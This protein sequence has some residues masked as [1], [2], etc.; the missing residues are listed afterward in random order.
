MKRKLTLGVLGALVIGGCGAAANHTTAGA[1][2]ASGTL[3]EW[4]AAVTCARA[5][6][7]PSLPDPV[8]GLDGRVTL[9]GLV[10]VPTPTPSVQSACAAQIRAIPTVGT[11][12]P[13][14]SAAFIHA[15]V[16]GAACLR[17]HGYP[18]WPDPDR[19]GVFHVR[20]ADAGTP[21]RLGG[22]ESACQALFPSG[23]RLRITP[24]G[25]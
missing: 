20:S 16:R 4:R 14:P 5:H 22:A 17:T 24:S 7:M 19:Q 11:A 13:N 15:E 2:T 10:R 6:G 23:W 18:S 3:V 12:S 25:K 8:V 1:Q 9:P 21:T